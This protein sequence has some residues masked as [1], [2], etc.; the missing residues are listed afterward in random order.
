MAKTADYGLGEFTYPRGWFMIAVSEDLTDKPQGVRYFG[1]DLALYRGK[2]GR[3]V[4][5]DAYCPHMGTHLAINTTSYV[6]RDHQHIEGDS[7]RCPY[8]AWRLGP[9][10]KVNDIPYFNGPIPQAACVRSWRIE[11]RYGCIWV[12][13]DPENGEPDYDLPDI[14]MWRDP[15]WVHWSIDRLGT[16]N[17][18]PQEVVD[19]IADF[20]HLSPIH[21]SRVDY[22]ENEFDGHIAKQRQ[23]GGHRTLVEGA[24]GFSTDTWYTGPAILLSR[25][26]GHY[27]TLMLITHTPVDDGVVKVWHG[28]LVKSPHTVANDADVAI[29]RGYQE[30]ARLAFA[31]DFEV[32]ANKAP[33]FQVL[34][35]PTDGPFAKARLWY[36]QFYNPRAKAV[37]Y[38]SRLSGV[39]R[40]P[41]LP[42][43]P[44]TVAAE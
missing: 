2:S 3:V 4:L 19:N 18:H 14:P 43:A 22:F 34:Q 24:E 39:Y 5:L 25:L 42:G 10:G 7:I 38:L 28:L 23:G 11:E 36:K 33:A 15:A 1:R 13:H 17:S 44:S 16:L 35:L 32:W 12:W 41:G 26:V 6:V 8:H 37:D 27:E 40:I 29:A 9:D 21:G 30:Q 31:Q 20:S